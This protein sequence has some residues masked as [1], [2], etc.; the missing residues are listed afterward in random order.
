MSI[1]KRQSNEMDE[2]KPKTQKDIDDCINKF[3]DDRVFLEECLSNKIL[4][5]KCTCFFTVYRELI[6]FV[7]GLGYALAQGESKRYESGIK[8]FDILYENGEIKG[9]TRMELVK[10][11]VI[12]CIEM[13]AIKPTY[14]EEIVYCIAKF[15]DDENFLDKCLQ[16]RT[17]KNKYF[18]LQADDQDGFVK[19]VI[20]LGYARAQGA[21][22]GGNKIDSGIQLFDGWYERGYII[23]HDR[24]EMV[25][26][27]IIRCIEMEAERHY[28]YLY[29]RRGEDFTNMLGDH[30]FNEHDASYR[31]FR[32]QVE[33]SEKDWS[34]LT[35]NWLDEN[36]LNAKPPKTNADKL[37][38]KK[39]AQ[40]LATRCGTE[41]IVGD[42]EEHLGPILHG[43]KSSL[44]AHPWCYYY[45]PPTGAGFP[46]QLNN[47]LKKIVETIDNDIVKQLEQLTQQKVNP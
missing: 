45:D 20:G 16:N 25:K 26:N 32:E 13:E 28:R 4:N 24:M 38:I 44:G 39:I 31:A 35:E 19:T 27:F 15:K 22:T 12:R 47:H 40:F 7:I 36:F 9:H 33:S 5:D 2:N 10:S 6:K 46:P 3:K 37:K 43:K 42:V 18:K 21:R 8:L 34:K 41:A 17:L 30:E 29:R 23:G 1:F 11:F 14:E